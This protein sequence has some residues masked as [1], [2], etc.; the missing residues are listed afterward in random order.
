[1]KTI[2]FYLQDSEIE[3][4]HETLAKLE[5]SMTFSNNKTLQDQTALQA[6]HHL[7]HQ[8]AKARGFIGNPKKAMDTE[9]RLSNLT[10]GF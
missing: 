4:L 10:R 8:L 1:M 2:E 7:S 5:K 6:L 3:A 9:I